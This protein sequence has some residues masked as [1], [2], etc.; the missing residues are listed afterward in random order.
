MARVIPHRSIETEPHPN[1]ESMVKVCPHCGTKNHPRADI[2][3]NC[4]TGLQMVSPI[5]G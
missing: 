4:Q 1:V 5:R 2:C 3:H